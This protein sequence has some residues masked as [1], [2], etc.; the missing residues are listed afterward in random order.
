[1]IGE[2]IG[3]TLFYVV[4]NFIGGT[5]RWF[6]GT[7][8]ALLFKRKKYNYKEYIYGP[9]GAEDIYNSAH[10]CFNIILGILFIVLIAVIFI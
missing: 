4:I 3:E 9:D 2:I 6:I 8:F 7:L 1:M 10:G 5:I